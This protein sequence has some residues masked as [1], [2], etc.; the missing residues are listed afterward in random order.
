MSFR[1]YDSPNCAAAI[2]LTATHAGHNVDGARRPTPGTQPHRRRSTIV[3][4]TV[5]ILF[6]AAI[7]VTSPSA[8]GTISIAVVPL[9]LAVLTGMRLETLLVVLI[10]ST[11]LS[12]WRFG[13]VGFHFLPEHVAIAAF[14]S[15][16]VMRRPFAVLRRPAA[17]ELLFLLWILWNAVAS[18]A[19]S[20]DVRDSL[21]IVGWLLLAWIILWCVRGYVELHRIEARRALELGMRTA[22]VLGVIAGVLWLAAL[23]GVSSFGVQPEYVTGTVAAR[24]LSFEANLFGSLELFWL[25]LALRWRAVNDAAVSPLQVFGLVVGIVASMTR[26]VWLAGLVVVIVAQVARWDQRRLRGGSVSGEQGS[27]TSLRIVACLF[28]LIAL[29]AFSAPAGKKLAAALDF[30]SSTGLE[31][32][33]N[34]NVALDD[35]GS[36]GG[37]VLG[38]GTNSYGQRH[39]SRTVAGQPD[40]L[41]NLG[42][43]ILYDT[44]LVGVVLFGA[45]SLAFVLHRHIGWGRLF[46]L[47]F[48]VALMIVGAAAS[49]IWFGY[50]WITLAAID[51]V[52]RAED[53]GASLVLPPSGPP[54]QRVDPSNVRT[55]VPRARAMGAPER[56]GSRPTPAR[57]PLP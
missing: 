55:N 23:A 50:V 53:M 11:Q 42:L 39:L 27:R 25:F 38:R 52:W 14:A 1:T 16:L 44:G 13:F 48:V 4:A 47:F 30:R 41:G 29:V 37:Y 51:T 33:R 43:T 9:C 32:V 28:G 24:G 7:A 57:P 22:A 10:V 36:S 46:K 34:W 45:A 49:P 18:L 17:Y 26:A 19:F 20:V 35:L 31:R 5:A 15:A 40:Y 8:A 56:D 12:G 54:H 6:G 21:A 3:R 2:T